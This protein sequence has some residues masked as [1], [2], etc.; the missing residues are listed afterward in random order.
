MVGVS[1][2]DRSSPRP[3]VSSPSRDHGGQFE[4]VIRGELD[5]GPDDILGRLGEA[6]P[7]AAEVV[8][9]NTTAVS[10]S[11]VEPGVGF[12]SLST[13]ANVVGQVTQT[14]QATCEVDLAVAPARSGWLYRPWTILVAFVTVGVIAALI[15]QQTGVGVALSAMGAL[16]GGRTAISSKRALRRAV[17]RIRVSLR[18]P[19]DPV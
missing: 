3:A 17:E 15:A 14:S 5:G 19:P 10:G 2:A 18:L 12:F 4:W 16:Y 6:V 7:V 1:D 9:P 13:D 8:S 11:W